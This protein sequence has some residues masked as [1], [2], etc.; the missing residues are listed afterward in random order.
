MIQNVMVARNM[1]RIVIPQRTLDNHL[2][3]LFSLG[4]CHIALSLATIYETLS[5]KIH[6]IGVMSVSVY[7]CIAL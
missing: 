5:R 3:H 6:P 4:E 2:S 7:Q 1:L